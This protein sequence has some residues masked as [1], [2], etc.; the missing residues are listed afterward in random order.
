MPETRPAS[1]SPSP[2]SPASIPRPR[3]LAGL[4]DYAAAGRPGVDVETTVMRLRRL[5]FLKTTLTKLMAAHFCG[6]PEW[7]VKGAL[8]LHLWQDAEHSTWL[9]ARITEMRTP[10]HHLDRVPA[11]ELGAFAEELL[12][13]EN[14]L[15][16]LAGLYLVLKPATLAALELH[17]AHAHPVADQ[18]TR[19]LFR[20]I[21]QEEREQIAWGREA[22]DALALAADADTRRRIDAWRGHLAVC[23]AA[24]GG[25][26]G[27]DPAP[28][29]STSAPLLPRRADRP[30]DP[31]RVPRRDARFPHVWNSR[32]IVP[33]PDRPVHERLWW[34]LNVRLQEMHVPELVATV[35]HDWKDQPWEFYH[36]LARHL[37]DEVRHSML[38]EAAFALRGVDFTQIPSH[39]GFAAYPNT[40]LSPPDR[41]AFLWGIEQGLMVK[42][43][44]QAEVALAKAGGDELAT[45]FQ[46]FDW[47]DEVLHAQIG[48][49]WLEPHYGAREAMNA[50]YERVRPAYDRMKDEDLEK[51]GRDWWPGFY[52]RHLRHL[53][54]GSAPAPAD[55]APPSPFSGY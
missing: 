9:R 42:S 31:P 38:G 5:V 53:D 50:A 40:Q 33:P 6:V 55:S 44:K 36:D 51:P 11:P 48:R 32:G 39:V 49:R 46:D 28:T 8:G 17:L 2:A 12:R 34:M 18:P 37:W 20:F 25:I 14:T 21:A 16:L 24:A 4:C 43:G 19:R 30:F 7:E 47:A 52:A 10:P 13:A 3:P 22:F 29:G 54:P 23:L 41:Y 15:E 45:L 1:S 27:E 26:F 35:L